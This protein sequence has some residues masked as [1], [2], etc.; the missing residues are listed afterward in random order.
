MRR[1]NSAYRAFIVP[2]VTDGDQRTT[3]RV[4]LLPFSLATGH[5]L[6][7]VSADVVLFSP[8]FLTDRV[9]SVAAECQAIKRCFRPFQP[10]V[11]HFFQNY[12]TAID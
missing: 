11:V 3:P 4:L 12:P 5:N 10:V 1:G 8:L 6:Q 2:D 7:F 9:A